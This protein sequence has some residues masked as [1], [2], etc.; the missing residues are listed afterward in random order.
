MRSTAPAIVAHS[1]A[2]HCGGLIERRIRP[3]TLNLSAVNPRG[4]TALAA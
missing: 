2:A 4:P 1:G 3:L